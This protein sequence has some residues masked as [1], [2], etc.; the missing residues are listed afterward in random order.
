MFDGKGRVW[1]AAACRGPKNPDFCKKGSEHPSAKAF[2]IET[3][4]RQVAMLDP[5]TMKYTFVDTCFASHHLQFD[6]KDRLCT[7][8]A[9]GLAGWI[10]MKMFDQTGDAA[11]SQGWSPFV[12]DINGN[13]KRDEYT[14]PNPPLD[15]AKDMRVTG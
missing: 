12:L 7:S 11:K 9:G 1:L 15:T 5:A 2:P 10:D 3:N 13:G 14:E 8:G 4:V 6:A